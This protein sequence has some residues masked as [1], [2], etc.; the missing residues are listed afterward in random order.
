MGTFL[1]IV[2]SLTA[3][4]LIV[5]AGMRP[6][7]GLVSH[8]ELDRRAKRGLK[9]AKQ[10]LR[11]EDL[12]INI[13]SLQRVVVALLLVTSVALLVVTF[14]W[15]IGIIVAII[16]ALE[17]G[18]IAR[19]SFLQRPSQKLYDFLEPSLL[20]FAEKAPGL[21]VLL[22]SVPSEKFDAYRR[23]DSREELQHLVSESEDVLTADEKKLIVHSLSFADQRVESVMTPKSMIKTVKSSE[24]L[25][26]LVL[27]ELH[28]IGHSRLPV[29]A[30]DID[31]VVGILHTNDLLSLDRKQSVIAE[32]AMEPKVYY[33]RDDQ[34]LQ[35]AL[36]AFLRTH[37]HLFI[38]VN[39]FRET[40]G[41]ITIEDVIEELIGREIIDE[42]EGHDDLRTVALRNPND[43]NSPDSHQ[44]V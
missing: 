24:F 39:E 31:H 22:R 35:H 18:A 25:G 16:L 14:G 13:L 2:T 41:L 20:N 34:T 30:G 3:I 21:F 10:Q 17:Y 5:V 9:E 36:A 23:L 4:L 8:F 6:V 19:L 7:R 29:I 1:I 15:L 40:V 43:N 42:F 44:D 12:L 11:R 26:P 33:I 38:V 32:K 27:S 37:H 28:E